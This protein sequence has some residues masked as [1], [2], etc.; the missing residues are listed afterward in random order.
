[1]LCL[2]SHPIQDLSELQKANELLRSSTD[3]SESQRR[4]Q[5]EQLTA[6]AAREQQLQDQLE[7]LKLDHATQLEG[8]QLLAVFSSAVVQYQVK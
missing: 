8:Q 5:E 4:T 6:V 1:M 2:I 3:S 7:Q